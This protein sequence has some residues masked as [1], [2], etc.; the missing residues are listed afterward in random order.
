M[1][2]H[3][4][5]TSKDVARNDTAATTADDTS[6]DATSSSAF[7][8]FE[9]YEEDWSS[10]IFLEGSSF[11]CDEE[12][13]AERL[14]EAYENMLHRP[15]RNAKLLCDNRSFLRN[16]R[17]NAVV[18]KRHLDKDHLR[19]VFLPELEKEAASA[20]AGGDSRSL[21]RSSSSKFKESGRRRHSTFV[22]ECVCCRKCPVCQYVLFGIKLSFPKKKYHRRPNSMPDFDNAAISRQKKD[23]SRRISLFKRKSNDGKKVTHRNERQVPHVEGVVMEAKTFNGQ[24]SLILSNTK[25][26]SKQDRVACPEGQLVNFAT[27]VCTDTLVQDEEKASLDDKDYSVPKHEPEHNISES[28]NR[29]SIVVTRN[30]LPLVARK[31]SD[32]VE[33]A[34]V[35]NDCI[36]EESLVVNPTYISNELFPLENFPLKDSMNTM[37]KIVDK[38]FDISDTNAAIID[39]VSPTKVPFLS[40]IPS[41]NSDGSRA[42]KPPRSD[43]AEYNKINNNLKRNNPD[44]L[45][46]R[47]RTFL[48]IG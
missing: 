46:A 17:R 10:S 19:L 38:T 15:G 29:I 13:G 12:G 4:D 2:R 42:A 47:Q 36:R 44:F 1:Y 40:Q 48:L 43:N 16:F 11:V 35:V 26:I 14:R 8:H 22:G 45:Q 30:L 25:P 27:P 41:Y 18:H 31:K 24:S 3:Y 21:S 28:R 34:N 32:Q 39:V 5:L 33:Q 6:P 9:K 20:S 23:K 7:T 37:V